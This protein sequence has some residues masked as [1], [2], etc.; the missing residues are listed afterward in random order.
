M[1]E[2][3]ARPLQHEIETSQLAERARAIRLVLTDCDGVLTDGRIRYS[4]LGEKLRRFSNA[5]DAAIDSLKRSGISTAI[6]TPD[7]SSTVEAH[8]CALRCH[9]FVG[10]GER[11]L[12]FDQL[13][14]DL[15]LEY[16]Q[17]AYVGHDLVGTGPFERI[18]RDGLWACPSG[19]SSS[20][21]ARAH[22]RC[23]TDGGLGALA[24]YALWLIELR[25]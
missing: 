11:P 16:R 22:F 15:G 3:F 1:V 2:A 20:T 4:S 25:R 13:R 5:D 6:L 10:I 12:Y 19:V 23:S 8:A 7:A 14:A 24:E 17:L 18:A 9:H 21:G